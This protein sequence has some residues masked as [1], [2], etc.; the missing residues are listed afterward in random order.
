MDSVVTSQRDRIDQAG[1][2]VVFSVCGRCGPTR[3]ELGSDFGARKERNKSGIHSCCLQSRTDQIRSK[4]C[5]IQFSA[6]DAAR[7][8]SFEYAVRANK[9]QVTVLQEV[10]LRLGIRK[11]AVLE[12]EKIDPPQVNIRNPQDREVSGRSGTRRGRPVLKPFAHLAER[13]HIP[14][15]GQPADLRLLLR[16][17]AEAAREQLL[18]RGS[19]EVRRNMDRLVLKSNSL[20]N[21]RERSRDRPLFFDRRIR[22]L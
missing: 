13:H 20:P 9:E 21:P 11:I 17:A 4:Q 10:L 2:Q 5:A 8:E 3:D 7:P 1:I 16:L 12:I 18:Q 14:A 6:E 19:L 22:N 15:F